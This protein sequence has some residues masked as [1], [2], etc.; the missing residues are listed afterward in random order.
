MIDFLRGC[1]ESF[2]LV[3]ALSGVRGSEATPKAIGSRFTGH[4]AYVRGCAEFVPSLN[5]IQEATDA[6]NR[7]V[8]GC[9]RVLIAA[10]P[11]ISSGPLLQRSCGFPS[12]LARSAGGD[13]FVSSYFIFGGTLQFG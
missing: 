11:T 6:T 10:V 4:P 13:H 8:A 5:A 9:R 2:K 7:S 1:L 12:W 3:P